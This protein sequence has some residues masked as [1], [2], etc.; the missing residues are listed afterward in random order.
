MRT[1]HLATAF[2]L[3]LGVAACDGGGSGSGPAGP[4]GT[5]GPTGSAGP[6]GPTGP[7]GPEGPTGPT[8]TSATGSGSSGGV[9]GPTGPTGPTGPPGPMGL[10]GSMGYPG[11]PGAPGLPG[12][13]GAPGTP[14]V[15][16]PPGP[17][18][19]TGVTGPSGIV[20]VY[21]GLGSN[22]VLNLPGSST[23]IFGG[24][25]GAPITVATSATQR[26]SAFMSGAVEVQSSSS[27]G[28]IIYYVGAGACYAAHGSGAAPLALQNISPMAMQYTPVPTFW[29]WEFPVTDTSS[30]VPGGDMPGSC[31]SA[32]GVS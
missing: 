28:E 11:A 26:V 31:G 17:P 19:T 2:L 10:T 27:P 23:C 8:G 7:S 29:D 25:I 21:A 4:E 14:G 16:G 13:P 24:F 6:T 32:H 22:G 15:T 5:S 30:S 12:T 20:G 3:G 18:G 1:T 9:E